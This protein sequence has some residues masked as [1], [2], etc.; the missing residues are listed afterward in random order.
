MKVLKWCRNE[1]PVGR[2]TDAPGGILRD[3]ASY[4]T[5]CITPYV[6]V[7]VSEEKD[8]TGVGLAPRCHFFLDLQPF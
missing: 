1:T 2:S 5:V 7:S 4:Y 8:E 3:T 6:F